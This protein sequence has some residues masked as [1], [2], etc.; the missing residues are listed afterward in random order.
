MAR[1]RFRIIGLTIAITGVVVGIVSCDAMGYTSGVPTRLPWP[2]P[3]PTFPPYT[4]EPTI[5]N[6]GL[7]EG[8]PCKP[9]CWEGLTPGISTEQDVRQ[10]LQQLQDNGQIPGFNC[11]QRACQSSTVMIFWDGGIVTSISGGVE[12][13][14]TAQQLI[15]LIGP[16]VAVYSVAG[17]GCDMCLPYTEGATHTVSLGDVPAYFFYPRLGAWFGLYVAG[18]EAGCMCPAMQVVGFEY[19]P[20]MTLEQLLD[21]MIGSTVPALRGVE[22]SDLVEWYGF[23]PGYGQEGR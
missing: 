20:P 9:P 17:S 18:A 8:F 23:G 22:E 5:V 6:R 4:P 11:S 10:T 3:M 14:F 19:L 15:D 12:F 21:Y 13:D 16:P 1:T 7:A 2:S